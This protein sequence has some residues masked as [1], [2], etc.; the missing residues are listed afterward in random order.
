MKK[1]LNTKYGIQITKP[2][3]NEMYDH[4]DTVADL[5]K[6]EILIKLHLAKESNDEVLLRKV[7]SVVCPSGYGTGYNFEDIYNETIKNLDEVQNFW[8]NDEYPYGVRKGI[9]PEV[10]LEFIG[11]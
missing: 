9:V 8:L 11:Y 3:S 2:W 7:S 4:N 5:M 10:E 6:A 1:A